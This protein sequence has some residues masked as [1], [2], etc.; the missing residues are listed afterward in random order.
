MTELDLDQ[1][2]SKCSVGQLE[3]CVRIH[4]K[5]AE[6]REPQG[7]PAEK[8]TPLQ[9]SKTPTRAK[10]QRPHCVTICVHLSLSVIFHVN[11][12]L[13]YFYTFFNLPFYNKALNA[14]CI[15]NLKT[16]FVRFLTVRKACCKIFSSLEFTFFQP[17]EMLDDDDDDD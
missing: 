8:L 2:L 16:P 17:D 3:E 9:T 14:Y 5:G 10:S 7:K 15:V 13:F 6:T 11:A 12:Y 4:R 1:H